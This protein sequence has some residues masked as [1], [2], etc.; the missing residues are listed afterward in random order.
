MKAYVCSKCK[1]LFLTNIVTV[2]I[3]SAKNKRGRIAWGRDCVC[4][5]CRKKEAEKGGAEE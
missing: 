1:K 2:T 3:N 4:D 5:E